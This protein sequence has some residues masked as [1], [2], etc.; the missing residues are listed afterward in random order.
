M[1]LGRAEQKLAAGEQE[2]AAELVREARE[3]TQR[4]LAELRDL[5]RGIRPALL[6]ERGL[7]EAITSLAGARR[8]A[9]R[10]SSTASAAASTRR[11]RPP[12]TS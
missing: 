5:A 9:R 6:S 3:E 12:P 2:G 10:R 8:R 4:A 1:D 11:S 7:Q